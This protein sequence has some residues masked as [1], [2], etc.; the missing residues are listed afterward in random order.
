MG[1]KSYGIKQ[2]MEYKVKH[3]KL[4]KRFVFLHWIPIIRTSNWYNIIEP[5]SI[6]INFWAEGCPF[7][8]YW[9]VIFLTKG[10]NLLGNVTYN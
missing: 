10:L 5:K 6:G 7:M 9:G 3:K 2:L 8:L 4:Y 1:K